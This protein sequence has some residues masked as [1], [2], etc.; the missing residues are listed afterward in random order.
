MKCVFLVKHK[1]PFPK[2]KHVTTENLGYVHSDLWGSVSNEES[3]SGCK[4]FLTL[5][6]DFSNEG[7]DQVSSI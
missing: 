6:D 4:Y 2:A 1:L 5:I 3:L 7:L